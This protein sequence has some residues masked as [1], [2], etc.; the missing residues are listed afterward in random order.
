MK[1]EEIKTLEDVGAFLKE[2]PDTHTFGFWGPEG[3]LVHPNGDPQSGI[4]VVDERVPLLAKL[5]SGNFDLF[6]I[7][8]STEGGG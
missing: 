5:L 8:L 3:V 7:D 6:G 1:I 2:N 4:L